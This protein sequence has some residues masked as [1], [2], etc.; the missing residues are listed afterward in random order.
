MDTKMVMD[1][2]EGDVFA[3]KSGNDISYL[4]AKVL[5]VRSKCLDDVEINYEFEMFGTIYPRRDLLT[6]KSYVMMIE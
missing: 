3:M 1:L 5:S 4:A 6:K 2:R